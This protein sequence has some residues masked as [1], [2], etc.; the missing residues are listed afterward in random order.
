VNI[1]FYMDL[2][3][4]SIGG[5]TELYIGWNTTDSSGTA[6]YTYNLPSTRY[7]G[8][9]TWYANATSNGQHVADANVTRYIYIYG[10]L[11]VVFNQTTVNPNATYLTGDTIIVDANVYSLGPERESELNSS[12]SAEVNSTLSPPMLGS[13]RSI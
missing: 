13:V 6:E 8:N 2:T 9:Y 10:G 11:D 4:P 5:Q 12:Y 1:T 3:D 7:A